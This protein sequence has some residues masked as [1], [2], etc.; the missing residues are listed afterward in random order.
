MCKVAPSYGSASRIEHTLRADG[1][2]Y[3]LVE[4]YGKEQG[5]YQLSMECPNPPPAPPPSP[6]PPSA[7]RRGRQLSDKI[8]SLAEPSFSSSAP[9]AAELMRRLADGVRD[10]SALSLA[11]WALL[12]ASAVA[13][14]AARALDGLLDRS[15]H[16]PLWWRLLVHTRAREWA[17]AACVFAAS[18]SLAWPLTR[19]PG[20]PQTSAQRVATV[21][22]ALWAEATILALVSSR[23]SAGANW[24]FLRLA[25][26]VCAGALCA[27]AVRRVL[28]WA[29]SRPALQVARADGTGSS[30]VQPWSAALRPR[31][32]E[33]GVEG[34]RAEV[35]KEAPPAAAAEAAA[36]WRSKR[37]SISARCPDEPASKEACPLDD[38]AG[39]E[40]QPWARHN[41]DAS[42][43]AVMRAGKLMH[44]C[45]PLAVEQSD[46]SSGM[47]APTAHSLLVPA[48]A[49]VALP[50]F[51]A[52]ADR[53][54]A[55]CHDV[56]SAEVV[57]FFV[58]T[59]D[60]GQCS[61]AAVSAGGKGEGGARG[62]AA[63]P[64]C[65]L[66]PAGC[67]ALR[68]VPVLLVR[69]VEE[70]TD[71]QLRE[72]KPPASESH[73][74][75]ARLVECTLSAHSAQGARSLCEADIVADAADACTQL[76]S[77]FELNDQSS[78]TSPVRRPRRSSADLFLAPPPQVGT[79]SVADSEQRPAGTA[80]VARFCGVSEAELGAA[81]QW[82]APTSPARL[83]AGWLFVC[84]LLGAMG[85]LLL[86]AVPEGDAKPLDE[87]HMWVEVVVPMLL[88][89][90][91]AKLLVLEPIR[92]GLATGGSLAAPHGHWR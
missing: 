58:R 63:A 59:P 77:A 11:L 89:V 62:T 57:G 15:E 26:P 10:V 9:V 1:T 5:R 40:P 24:S 48:G 60:D 54:R 18:S 23:G 65:M 27:G 92:A 70:T 21:C 42:P 79:A 86:G 35:E 30:S 56:G 16:P 37:L 31:A 41:T 12:A 78:A 68:F 76:L 43:T 52:A 7:A 4:G 13:L 50:H 44:V 88:A 3:I 14:L 91:V 87:A 22:A 55:A 81:R 61:R 38:S 2:Y 74:P 20:E 19:L 73:S 32:A 67:P 36:G 75:R 25:L 84:A 45:S 34:M 66:Q 33:Q 71:E 8:G 6:P 39:N 85:A 90:Q 72:D 53:R 82:G 49:L 80:A 51:R 69:A 28:R 47:L 29:S 64:A 17:G 83:C 46:W